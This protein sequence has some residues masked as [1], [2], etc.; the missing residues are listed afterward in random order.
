MNQETTLEKPILK[1][2]LT[3]ENINTFNNQN[4][5]YYDNINNKVK[6]IK[7]NIY[8]NIETAL[9]RSNNI[10][11]IIET[12]N[13]LETNSFRFNDNS[14]K[15]KRKMCCE[16]HLCITYSFIIIILLF[17]IILWTLCGIKF[18]NC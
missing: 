11:N 7:E 5:E 4:D 12:T 17:I 1:S 13:S 3:E 8:N 2:Q 6:N 16:Q 18:E 9:N 10:N 14:K 15:I